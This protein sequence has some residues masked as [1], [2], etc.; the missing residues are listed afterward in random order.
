MGRLASDRT[1]AARINASASCTAAAHRRHRQPSARA[2]LRSSDRARCARSGRSSAKTTP[3]Q[4]A[5]RAGSGRSTTRPKPSGGRARPRA[6]RAVVMPRQPPGW[7]EHLLHHVLR[8][9]EIPRQTEHASRV[10]VIQ[11]RG[12]VEIALGQPTNQRG[13]WLEASRSRLLAL[14][15]FPRHPIYG[16]RRGV[17]GA[18]PGMLAHRRRPPSLRSAATCRFCAALQLRSRTA[19]HNAL[20]TC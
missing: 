8:V 3:P 11:R 15:C 4:A 19:Y 5:A 6:T 20:S 13:I 9:A 18:N 10:A 16:C 7:R 2:M 17:D 14:L 12:G 1:R